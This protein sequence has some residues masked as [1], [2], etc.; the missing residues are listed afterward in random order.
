M[1][2]RCSRQPVSGGP[3]WAEPGP[4]SSGFFALPPSPCSMDLLGWWNRAAADPAPANASPK[5]TALFSFSWKAAACAGQFNVQI[6]TKPEAIGHG[7]NLIHAGATR[8]FV[9]I[10]IAAFGQCGVHV[11]KAMA[12]A[13]VAV[14]GV[15]A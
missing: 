7:G 3:H 5:P 14:P 11:D 13:G 10:D 4:A 12:A 8:H 15:V 9:E 2:G 6:H 1:A